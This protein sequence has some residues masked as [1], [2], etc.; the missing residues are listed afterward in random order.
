[1]DVEELVGDDRDR[2]GHCVPPDGEGGEDDRS[3]RTLVRQNRIRHYLLRRLLVRRSLL[4]VRHFGSGRAHHPP[5]RGHCGRSFRRRE[6]SGSRLDL[7]SHRDRLQT[8]LV[9]YVDGRLLPVGSGQLRFGGDGGD[10]GDGPLRDHVVFDGGGQKLVLAVE[11]GDRGEH[12]GHDL[13]AKHLLSDLLW[14]CSWQHHVS[15]EKVPRSRR[16]CL[17]DGGDVVRWR[18][19]STQPLTGQTLP[20]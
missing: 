6:L 8:A 9:A 12:G 5:R 11:H 13:L 18:W 3:C 14:V 16:P 17:A 7:P 4:K 19:P 1:M 10:G 2:G 20:D 15:S